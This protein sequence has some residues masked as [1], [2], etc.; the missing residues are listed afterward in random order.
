V[1]LWTA[2]AAIALIVY[3]VGFVFLWCGVVY[4]QPGGK[5]FGLG[6]CDPPAGPDLG[7]VIVLTAIAFT[8]GEILAGVLGAT[9]GIAIAAGD[10]NRSHQDPIAN[11]HALAF[12]R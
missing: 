10:W 11:L 5:G 6:W 1:V 3:W 9:V 8:W 4:G 7:T 2:L 12:I